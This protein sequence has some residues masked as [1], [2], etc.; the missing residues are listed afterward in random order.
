MEHRA[1]EGGR[2]RSVW[3]CVLQG[4][5]PHRVSSRRK[6]EISVIEQEEASAIEI[7]EDADTV[8]CTHAGYMQYSCSP[9][10]GHIVVAVKPGQSLFCLLLGFALAGIQDAFFFLFSHW[11]WVSSV[12]AGLRDLMLC[13]CVWV[14]GDYCS[15][16]IYLIVFTCYH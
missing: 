10:S 5:T 14:L 2:R 6:V 9:L 13:V 8:G 15:P 3:I 4:N 1:E 7:S 16:N 12:A 11:S